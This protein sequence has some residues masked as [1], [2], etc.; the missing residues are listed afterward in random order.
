M[1]TFDQEKERNHEQERN[2]DRDRIRDRERSRTREPIRAT[3]PL[4]T[5]IPS[6]TRSSSFRHPTSSLLSSPRPAQPYSSCAHISPPPVLSVISNTMTTSNSS[7]QLQNET[8]APV[9]Q[10]LGHPY[11]IGNPAYT[12]ALTDASVFNRHIVRARLLRLPFID[13][14]TR[15]AQYPV[16]LLYRRPL[17]SSCI[18]PTSQLSTHV[19]K[20]SLCFSA[21]LYRVP[22]KRCCDSLVGSFLA[23]IS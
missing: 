21:S 19:G 6:S 18:C 2:R 4:F 17:S 7:S 12:A 23:S 13:A 5:S 16:P 10:V 20:D 9:S 1:Y 22:G 3:P 15:Q 11:L 8:T 14:A